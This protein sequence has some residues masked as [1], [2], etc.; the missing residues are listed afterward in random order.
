MK[1]EFTVGEID[2]LP[3]SHG[4]VGGEHDRQARET[5]LKV[6]GKCRFR[7]SWFSS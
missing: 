1:G 2:R 3:G 5:V 4:L 7:R 6:I